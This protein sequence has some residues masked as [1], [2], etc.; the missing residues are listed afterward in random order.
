MTA[1][2]RTSPAT[3]NFPHVRGNYDL[4]VAVFVA[5]LIISNVAATKLIQFGPDVLVGGFP[6]LPI[7]TDGGAFLF[8][9]TYVLGDVLAEVYGLRRA[10]RAIAVGFVMS[11]LMS[12]TFWL[13]SATPPAADWPNQDAWVAVLGFVPRIVL[14]SL[15][16]YL[17]GQLLN[18]WVLVRIKQR[19]GQ[20]RLWVRLVSSTIVGEF[21]DTLLFCTI[22]FGPLGAFLGGGS[23]P[24]PQ[25][26]N[27]I[28]VGFV[29]KVT[30]EILLLPITYRVIAG[31]K[32]REPDLT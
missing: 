6:V 22:A 8:P 10:R 2:L 7:I 26:I 4:I 27:Y 29:Y 23:I 16:G 11:A 17:A 20:Q 15:A 32:R 3:E 24:G 21:V 25:L 1:S 30:V 9:L 28:V 14:A 5:L 19:F 12:L 13:V 31:V 18:A